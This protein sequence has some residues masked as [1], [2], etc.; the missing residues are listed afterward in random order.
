MADPK[1]DGPNSEPAAGVNV[2]ALLAEV[3]QMADRV[4]N[5]IGAKKP[6]AAAGTAQTAKTEKPAD[7]KQDNLPSESADP[8]DD[9]TDQ[10]EINEVSIPTEP[11]DV[12]SEEAESA[13]IDPEAST[14]AVETEAAEGDTEKALDQHADQIAED[15]INTV[16]DRIQ[17]KE[18]ADE[19]ERAQKEHEAMVLQS[20]PKPV[21]ALLVVLLSVD[22]L[23][24]WVPRSVKN[25]RGL[26]GISTLLLA[27]MLWIIILASDS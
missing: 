14:P 5:L 16:L 11:S 12:D 2:D 4:E 6:V 7:K 13:A 20:M 8:T 17:K 1:V 23:F 21:K 10:S 22:R 25:T 15:E 3:K 19:A 27:V 9:P 26:I 18:Q 24:L